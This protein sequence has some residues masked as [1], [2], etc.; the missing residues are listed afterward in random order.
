MADNVR[1]FTITSLLQFYSYLKTNILDEEYVSKEDLNT[2]SY[3]GYSYVYAA[4]SYIINSIVDNEYV[5]AQTFNSHNDRLT[6]LESAGYLTT[7][8]DPTVPSY[9]KTITEADISNWN[10]AGGGTQSDWNE[11]DTSSDAYILNKP[12]IPSINGLVSQTSLSSNSYITSTVLDTRLNTAGYLTNHQSLDNYIT[13]IDLSNQSYVTTTDLSSQGYLTSHQDISGKADSSAAISSLSLSI[14]SSYQITLSGTKAD[15]T[16]FTVNDM[17]DLPLESVVVNGSFNNSTKKVVLTLQNG[18]DIEFS[19]ADLVNGL[20]TEITSSNKLSADLIQSGSTNV[21]VTSSD[22]SNWNSKTSNVGTITSIKM[23]NETKGSSGEVDLGTVLTSFTES[24]PTV[25]SYVKA[26]TQTDISNWNSSEVNIQADWNVSD[27]TSDA[28]IQN[29]PT[30]PSI[31]G[32]VSQATLS[33]Q[34]YITSTALD[35]RLNNAGYLTSETKANWNETDTSSAAYIQ[36]KP[37]I[38]AAANDSTITIQKG[39]T[40]VDTFTTNASSN[41]TINIPD[42]LPS[43]SSA[44]SG[45]IL[46]VNSS[47]ELVW[48]TAV[49]IYTG[50]TEPANSLGNDG[51]IYLQTS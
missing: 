37:A 19:V 9:V 38:P 33:A 28:Y 6:I 24:D 47:G 51:D 5:I 42:E 20:Q 30:I 12:S 29:K 45:K 22:V 10:N 7:E 15:N 50:S 3:A 14:N 46:S 49:S 1:D 16:T 2:S 48:I 34:S 4:Y 41:K 21:V 8:S 35:T 36:N 44:D 17:I 25:P 32:L 39:G 26:I 13:K 27:S 23:N 43:Y 31:D 18:S 40:N 11:S